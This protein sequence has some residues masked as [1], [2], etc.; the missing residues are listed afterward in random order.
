MKG[1]PFCSVSLTRQKDWNESGNMSRS[2][3]IKKPR[4]F[5]PAIY[6]LIGCED[7]KNNPKIT[8]NFRAIEVWLE[9]I[10]PR[11]REGMN[12]WNAIE[13]RHYYQSPMRYAIYYCLQECLRYQ[14]QDAYKLA[15]FRTL[16]LLTDCYGIYN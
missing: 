7:K 14:Y 11:C 13:C 12:C 5:A 1:N 4:S 16:L 9:L 2:F 15:L 3:R 6:N 10:N 8:L